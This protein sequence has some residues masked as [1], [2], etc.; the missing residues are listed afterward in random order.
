MESNLTPQTAPVTSVDIKKLPS[1]GLTYPEGATVSFRTYGYGEVKKISSSNLSEKEAFALVLAGINTNFNKFDITFGDFMYLAIF[2][3]IATLGTSKVQVPYKSPINGDV[4]LHTMSVEEL[5]VDDLDCPDLPLN[6]NLSDGNTLE[7]MPL[8]VGDII[9]LMDKGKMTDSAYLMAAQ[10]RSL[11]LDKAYHYIGSVSNNDDL[12]NLGEVE[13]I[14]AHNIKPLKVQCTEKDKN[15]S[16]VTNTVTIRLEGRQALLLPFRE[17]GV[18]SRSG[19]S[20]GKRDK[21]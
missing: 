3:K 5:E 2:R 6:L 21:P 8:T 10:C 7:F 19:I 20:F 11:S 13:R 12:V 9:S 1:K 15:G 18:P 16:E 17:Q 4:M 14:L